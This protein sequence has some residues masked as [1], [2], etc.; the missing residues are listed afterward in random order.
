MSARKIWPGAALVF[1]ISVGVLLVVTFLWGASQKFSA[2]SDP[3]QY[4]VMGRSLAAGLGFK[5]TAGFWPQVSDYSRMPAWPAIIAVGLRIFPGANPDAVARFA[6]AICL[7]LA[8]GFFCILCQRIGVG[9]RLS[10]IAGL[11]VSLS[12]DL[13]PLSVGGLSEI[14][15]V[16]IVAI[17][18]TSLLSGGPWFYLGA[19]IL[20]TAALVRTNFVLVPFIL[21]GFFVVLRTAGFSSP[22]NRTVVRAALA[23]TLSLIPIFVWVVR[24]EFLTGRFPLLSA[25][26]GEALYGSNNEVV[27]RDLEYWGYWV[28]PDQIPGETP[29]KDLAHQLPTDLALNDYY[30]AKAMAW[31]K[32]NPALLPRLEL[33]KFIRAFVPIPWRPLAA[34]YIAF[35]YRFVLWSL[36]VG[37][38]PWWA[39]HINRTYLLFCA[40]MAIVHLITTAVYYGTFRFTHCYMEIFFIPAIAYGIQEWRCRRQS[41]PARQIEAPFT[42]V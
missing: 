28:M 24:N 42:I 2:G 25:L 1:G 3:D 30:H 40:A 20:G 41:A 37:T 19:L 17:G 16:M 4:L 10:V 36:W 27:A 35:A 29:K 12:P 23:F 8:G 15:F 22:K 33:G 32:A 26:E 21:F 34:S 31:I 39:P 13:V 38:L 6:N 5:D 9:T 7:S 14:S 18:L 11:A